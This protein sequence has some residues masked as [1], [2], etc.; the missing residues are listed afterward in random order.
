MSIMSRLLGLFE[1]CGSLKV[2][3]GDKEVVWV[4]DYAKDEPRI[5]SKMSK[6]DIEASE[7]I[8]CLGQLKNKK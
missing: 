2:R 6:K 8:K 4:Y 5:L 7:R 1:R 3:T